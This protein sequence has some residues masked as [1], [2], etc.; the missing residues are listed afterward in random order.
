MKKKLA[1]I[2]KW[3]PAVLSMILWIGILVLLW[4]MGAR[5][6]DA[7]KRTPENILP[8]LKNIWN[9]LISS[10]KVAGGKTAIQVVMSGAGM[11]LL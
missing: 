11:T 6:M 1:A 7:T 2:P 8:H 9:A 5:K 4:E 10:K 3:V